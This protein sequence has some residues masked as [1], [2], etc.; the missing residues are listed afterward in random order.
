MDGGLSM[1]ALALLGPGQN[2]PQMLENSPHVVIPVAGMSLQARRRGPD[3]LHPG[4]S[5][6]VGRAW[7][8]TALSASVTL[9]LGAVLGAL[10]AL[11]AGNWRDPQTRD[12]AWVVIGFTG[13]SLAAAVTAVLLHRKRRRVLRDNG[14]AYVIRELASDWDRQ[15]EQAFLD[16][17]GR[18]FARVVKVPGPG[19]LGWPWD[20]PLG[21]GAQRWDGKAHRADPLVSVA[22][23]GG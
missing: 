14:T 6:T 2:R 19:Q 22:A 15:D 16:T 20:W 12:Q 8:I 18:Y 13:A 11:L 1:D 7:V 4:W 3:W 21:P 23:V 9:I 5:W 10:P 17:A